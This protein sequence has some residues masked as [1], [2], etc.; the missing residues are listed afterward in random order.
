[1]WKEKSIFLRLIFIFV[2]SSFLFYGHP[3]PFGKPSFPFT[4][5]LFPSLSFLFF[6]LFK[7]K[8]KEREG[9]KCPLKRNGFPEA[10]AK[11]RKI[12]DLLP[13]ADFLLILTW[14]SRRK[15]LA[16]GKVS[17]FWLGNHTSF[18]FSAFSF[19]T[20][21]PSTF[22]PEGKEIYCVRKE[23]GWEWAWPEN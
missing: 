1:M 11:P 6:F 16:V 22:H 20:Q 23:I 3:S 12:T 14:R 2:S 9:R 19:C 5:H 8:T 7:K 10:K 4:R 17:Y 18:P 21:F 15:W 13:T